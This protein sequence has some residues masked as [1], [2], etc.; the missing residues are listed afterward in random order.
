MFT[1]L[2]ND[3]ISHKCSGGYNC[4]LGAPMKK[5][6][7]CYDDLNY[8]MCRNNLCNRIHLSKRNLKPILKKISNT[9]I[10][11]SITNK[12]IVNPQTEIINTSLN[13]MLDALNNFKLN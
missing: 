6:Y 12:S 13:Y 11:T 10:N 3:C 8:N 9:I 4:K 5:Y 7:I 1:R 2:C